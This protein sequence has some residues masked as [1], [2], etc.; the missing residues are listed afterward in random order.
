MFGSCGI[1]QRIVHVHACVTYSP[2][3]VHGT[4]W[5]WSTASS[6]PSEPRT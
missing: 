6:V 4:S 2:V 1:V 5:V 3:E